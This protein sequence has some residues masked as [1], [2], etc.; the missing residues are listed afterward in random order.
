MEP[1]GRRLSQLVV[2]SLHSPYRVL[3]GES[4]T[5]GLSLEMHTAYVG[6]PR[7]SSV[8][9]GAEGNDLT[10]HSGVGIHSGDDISS[11]S[12]GPEGFQSC[13]GSDCAQSSL[14]GCA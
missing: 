5:R 12:M 11:R 4:H 9:P 14:F 6:R 3:A 2:A 8:G 13:V 1:G 10:G 7:G